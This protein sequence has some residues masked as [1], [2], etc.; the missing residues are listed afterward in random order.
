MVWPIP[1][2]TWPLMRVAVWAELSVAVMLHELVTVIA[3]SADDVTAALALCDAPKLAP[4][5]AHTINNFRI[6]LT[7]STL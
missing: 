6:C 4:H 7:M 3:A 1:S 2:L 5:N